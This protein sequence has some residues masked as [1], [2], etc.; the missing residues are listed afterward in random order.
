MSEALRANGY[1]NT[2]D[3]VDALRFTTEPLAAMAGISKRFGGVEVLRDVR[4]EVFGGEVHVLAGENGAG[5]STL[6]KILAGVH[7]DYQGTIEIDGRR[8]R[9][10]SPIE[11]RRWASR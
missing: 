9:P 1:A 2:Y 10:R 11:A 3:D 5:K 7:T 4:F 6:I 8:V